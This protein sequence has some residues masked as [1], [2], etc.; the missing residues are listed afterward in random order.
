MHWMDARGWRGSRTREALIFHGLNSNPERSL[1]KAKVH[2]KTSAPAIS[3][4]NGFLLIASF[5]FF[6]VFGI[7]FLC[8][9]KGECPEEPLEGASL[10]GCRPARGLCGLI[11]F[12]ANDYSTD[13]P[14]HF[15][16]LGMSVSVCLPRNDS[17]KAD[18]PHLDA[19]RRIQIQKCYISDSD[20]REGK[21]FHLELNQR[22]GHG[23][24]IGN[25][26]NHSK[27]EDGSGGGGGSLE[28]H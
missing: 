18:R 28:T 3:F 23:G 15:P 22:R 21:E 10:A 16:F 27:P 19:V 17:T 9:Q 7:A 4:S 13:V 5:G 25:L 8:I 1:P 11:F 24:Y 2:H 12:K 20:E 14:S 26:R 6:A